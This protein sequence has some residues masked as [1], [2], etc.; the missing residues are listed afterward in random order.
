MAYSTDMGVRAIHEGIAA[1]EI[2]AREVAQASFAHI[3]QADEQVHAYLEL[4]EEAAYAAARQG[5]RG[6]GR[7]HLR[8]DGSLAGVPVAFKDNM[9]MEGTH[10]TCLSNVENSVVALYAPRALR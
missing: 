7:R 6:R 5:G 1:K 8:R 10:T 3:A 4:T 9:N 2:S